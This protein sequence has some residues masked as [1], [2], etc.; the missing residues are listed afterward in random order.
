[1]VIEQ[2]EFQKFCRESRSALVRARFERGAGPVEVESKAID[3]V[4]IG[5]W[6]GNFTGFSCQFGELF[7]RRGRG[8][9]ARCLMMLQP[10]QPAIDAVDLVAHAP[11]VEGRQ[12]TY[13]RQDQREQGN[14]QYDQAV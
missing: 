13:Q 12:N 10:G 3:L 8:N 5:R 9:L 6:Q 7:Q 2:P 14:G 1:M 11:A 4:Y